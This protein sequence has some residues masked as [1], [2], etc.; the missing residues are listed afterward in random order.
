MVELTNHFVIVPVS[1]WSHL[2]LLLN[3]TLNLL[4][5]HPSTIVTFLITTPTT[6]RLEKEISLHPST[7]V[8]PLRSRIRVVEMESSFI[9]GTG[10]S[11]SFSR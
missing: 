7:Y 10:Q 2:R 9:P 11:L 8:V 1:A 6:L 3:F 5:I 4:T